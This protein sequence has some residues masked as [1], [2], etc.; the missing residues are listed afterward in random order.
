MLDPQLTEDNPQA[1]SRTLR[2]FA[3]LCVL[4]F[5]GIACW[6]WFG[7]EHAGAALVNG[8]LALGLGMLGLLRPQALRPLF[9]GWMALAA[10]IGWAV[11]HVILAVLFYGLFTPIH[12][13]FKLVGQDPLFRRFPTEQETC[14]T[15]KEAAPGIQSYFRQS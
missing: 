1:T 13:I 6:Q 5:G 3:G 14:W 4:F 15:R 10:P 11:S 7:R 2:E 12:L 9:V 8:I